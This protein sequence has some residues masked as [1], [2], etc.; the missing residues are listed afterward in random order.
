MNKNIIY[1]ISGIIILVLVGFGVD[2]FVGKAKQKPAEN[3]KKYDNADQIS[4]DSLGV[5]F[6]VDKSMERIEQK[7]LT[8][9]NPFFIYGFAPKDV[10]DVGCYISQTKRTSAGEVTLDYLKQGT[11]DQIKKNYSDAELVNSAE[12]VFGEI[13]G[14]KMEIKYKEGDKSVKMIEA[15]GTNDRVTTFAFCSTPESLYDFYKDKFGILFD[16][17]KLKK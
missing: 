14:V 6:Y 2:Y 12:V 13:K 10:S 9:K 16:S 11:F 1:I 3:T 8:T 5:S 15:V 4:D 17:L 7:E